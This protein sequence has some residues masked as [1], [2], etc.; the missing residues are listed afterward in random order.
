[1]INKIEIYHFQLCPFSR[2]LRLLLAEKNIEFSL[3]YEPFWQR[4]KGFIK[5]NPTG[6]TPTVIINDENIIWGNNAIC[7]FI[8]DYYDITDLNKDNSEKNYDNILNNAQIRKIVEWFDNKFYQEVTK[9]ILNEKIIKTISRMSYPDSQ[10][11]RVAKT[12][13]HYH[14][15][16]ITHLC[17]NHQYL[18]LDQITLADFAAASQLSVLD[19]VD[20]VPWQSYKIVRDWY[21]LIKSR[22]AFKQILK[23]RIA[24]LVPP[25]HYEDPDFFED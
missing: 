11:I 1:M 4:R 12:N 5:I 20:D 25:S 15:E 10:A 24:N 6:L 17:R 14:L 19:Y 22:P 7:E 3:K 2:K 21:R 16:F 23:D 13:I 18:A 8:S 9:Y